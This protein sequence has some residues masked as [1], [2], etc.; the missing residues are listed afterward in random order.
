MISVSFAMLFHRR[1][2]Y[3]CALSQADKNVGE[4]ATLYKTSRYVL[5]MELDVN[6]RT[7]LIFSDKSA[8][9]RLPLSDTDANESTLLN[10]TVIV[11]HDKYTGWVGPA[12]TWFPIY[13]LTMMEMIMRSQ[14]QLQKWW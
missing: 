11:G 7:Q 8:L 14:Q 12:F 1:L 9:R 13:C 4:L 10:D 6:D 5:H 3:L 2:V